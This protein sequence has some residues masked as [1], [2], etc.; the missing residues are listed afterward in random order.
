MIEP[1]R[2][3][4]AAETIDELR[5]RLRSVRWPDGVTDSGGVPLA[6]MRELARYWAEEFDWFAREASLN[7][8]PHFRATVD[9]QRIHFLHLRAERADA[10]PLLLLHGWPGSFVEFL[11]VAPRLAKSFHVVVPS[12]PGY[13]FSDPPR[14]PGMSNRRIAALLASLMSSLGYE[15]FAVQGGDWGAGIA[16]WLARDGPS[17]VAALHLNYIPGSY[18]PFVDGALTG[19]EVAFL[20]DRDSW[21]EQSGAYGH[22]QRTR[23]LTLAY[24]LSDSPIGLAAWIVEKFEEWADPRS[25]L[26]RDEL[27]TNVTIYWITNTIGSSVRL[28]LESS[29]TPHRFERGERVRVPCAIAHFPHEAPFPPRAWI[30]RA[31]DVVR[32]TEMPRGGHFAA[33]EEPELLAGDVEG[34]LR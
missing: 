4:V 31:Y 24:A 26:S 32:W 28:Y 33:I 29:R 17:R 16:T 14:E 22:L 1:F 20:R 8:L 18:E 13:G 19:E 7:E 2:I 30:E 10:L 15:R 3:R 9:G 11:G 25:A 21:S 34:F 27:L 6:S 12:L 5:A 23:P